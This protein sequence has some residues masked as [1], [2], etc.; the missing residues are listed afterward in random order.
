MVTVKLGRLPGTA[1]IALLVTVPVYGGTIRALPM[2]PFDLDQSILL[3]LQTGLKVCT[4]PFFEIVSLFRKICE[5]L[6][7]TRE[8]ELAL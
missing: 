6:T 8:F 7:V 3:G 5:P 4:K 1:N 2:S